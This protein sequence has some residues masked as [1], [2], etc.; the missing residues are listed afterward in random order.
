MLTV[1]DAIP[2]SHTLAK[3]EFATLRLIKLGARIIETTSR[4]RVAFAAACPEATIIRHLA[5]VLMPAAPRAAGPS[6]PRSALRPQHQA[7][8]SSATIT[9][10]KSTTMTSDTPFW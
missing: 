5:S 3:A 7:K 1:R 8:T 9:Y 2:K 10:A 4:V 6:L